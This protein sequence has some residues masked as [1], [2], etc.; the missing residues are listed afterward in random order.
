M[1]KE[2]VINIKPYQIHA[3]DGQVINLAKKAAMICQYS[4]CNPLHVSFEDR[5]F[6]GDKPMEQERV[7][8]RRYR[9]DNGERLYKFISEFLDEMDALSSEERW[10]VYKLFHGKWQY[11]GN[12]WLKLIK[13]NSR[14]SAYGSCC[15]RHFLGDDGH[16]YIKTDN[17]TV[18]RMF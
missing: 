7:W 5:N 15:Y 14:L 4:I 16:I 18:F 2:N 3:K 10:D 8:N 11:L 12:K 9:E 6:Q 1:D 17:G 13:K